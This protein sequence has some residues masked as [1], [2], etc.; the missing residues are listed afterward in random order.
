MANK[1]LKVRVTGEEYPKLLN[2]L[3]A[4]GYHWLSGQRAADPPTFWGHMD[5]NTVGVR[6]LNPDARLIGVFPVE[7]LSEHERDVMLIGCISVDTAIKKLENIHHVTLNQQLVKRIINPYHDK[8]LQSFTKEMQSLIYENF[9][10][11]IVDLID[12]EDEQLI[13]VKQHAAENDADSVIC[14]DMEQL[15]QQYLGNSMG[16]EQFAYEVG[17]RYAYALKDVERIRNTE[18]DACAYR[19]ICDSEG[20]EGEVE[21]E[22]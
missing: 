6:I 16:L 15:Y 2:N 13:Y 22:R 12:T 18:V 19:G 9:H 8:G 3:E 1:S 21:E 10:I 4:L 14:K 17:T 5:E 11:D 7:V 20:H